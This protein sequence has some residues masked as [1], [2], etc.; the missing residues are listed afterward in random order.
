MRYRLAR[1]SG[2]LCNALGEIRIESR[3]HLFIV[4]TY[5]IALH[6]IF[7]LHCAYFDRHSLKLTENTLTKEEL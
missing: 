2:N 4:A 7:F 1:C 5:H 6:G 3:Q